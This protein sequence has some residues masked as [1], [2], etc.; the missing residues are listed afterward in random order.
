MTAGDIDGAVVLRPSRVRWILLLAMS[1][2]LVAVGVAIRPVSPTLGWCSIGFF[3]LCAAL[4]AA[5]LLPGASH[6]RFDAD[7]FEVR[8]LF[9]SRRFAWRD[10]ARVGSAQVGLRRIVCWDFAPGHAGNARMREINLQLSGFEAALP[11]TYGRKAEALAQALD[12]RRLAAAARERSHEA[13]S[14][15]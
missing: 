4:A 7:G 5:N 11:D 15:E 6:L 10:I 12:A 14:L 13:A 9:R 8:T 3:G 1:L 2:A